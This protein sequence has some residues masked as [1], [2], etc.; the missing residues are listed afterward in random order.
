MDL[1]ATY[2]RIARDWVKD[3]SVDAWW[4][5]GVDNFLSFLPSGATILDVGCGAGI[6]ARYLMENGFD[7]T[8]VD[9][10][11]SQIEVARERQPSGKFFVA[12]IK[13]SLNLSQPFDALFAQ[14]VLLHIPKQEIPGVL[15]NILGWLKNGGYFYLA[16]KE[17]RPGQPEEQIVTENDYGYDYERFFSYFTSEEL[18]GYLARQGLVVVYEKIVKPGR[19]NWI[20]IV[21]QK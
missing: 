12:D 15:A 17:I 8:G 19:T 18:R 2:N 11:E 20:Q 14:A 10:S 21:G 6:K 5:E 4:I 7:V 1:K 13:Q 9:F 3:H 16:V